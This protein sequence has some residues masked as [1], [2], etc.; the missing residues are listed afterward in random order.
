MVAV[1]DGGETEVVFSSVGKSGNDVWRR[2]YGYHI[3]APQGIATWTV[4]A[5]KSVYAVVVPGYGH[6]V[7]GDVAD[8]DVGCYTFFHAKVVELA[9]TP[10]TVEASKPESDIFGISAIVVDGDGVVLPQRA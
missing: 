2:C 10:L 5:D 7:L 9:V 6:T 3:S 8:R 1:A 4:F